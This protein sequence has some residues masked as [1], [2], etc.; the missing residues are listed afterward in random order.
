MSIATRLATN[1]PNSDL[2]EAFFGFHR[3]NPGVYTLFKEFSLEM[4]KTG[5]KHY[6]C[7]AI[8]NRV[9]WETDIQTDS[10]DGFK[11]N[12]NFYPYYSRLLMAQEL[13]LVGFFRTR[14]VSGG[15]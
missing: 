3:D 13:E 1:T 7:L 5:R 8:M 6:G 9:R 4:K 14:R 15:E 2:E 10:S 12:N 11:L